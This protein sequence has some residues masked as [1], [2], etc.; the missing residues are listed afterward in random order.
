MLVRHFTTFIDQESKGML[1]KE[2]SITLGDGQEVKVYDADVAGQASEQLI[3]FG[4]QMFEVWQQGP[5]QMRRGDDG[6]YYMK[7]LDLSVLTLLGFVYD[8]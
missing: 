8:D 3:D 1:D 6:I 4:R 2:A 7:M 5:A